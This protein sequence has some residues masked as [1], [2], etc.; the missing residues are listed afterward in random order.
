MTSLSTLG[1]TLKDW[2]TAHQ[3]PQGYAY[4]TELIEHINQATDCAWISR[5]SL[6]QL[7]TDWQAL[8]AS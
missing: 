8:Q 4:L 5:L 1:W 2:Q 7:Q 3:T 6:T